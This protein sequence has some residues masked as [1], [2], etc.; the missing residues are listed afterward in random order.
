[1]RRAVWAM[2]ILCLLAGCQRQT[3]AYDP[4]TALPKGDP[5]FPALTTSW[6]ID[7]AGVLSSATISEGDDICQKLQDDGI[8][9]VAVVVIRGVK[10]PEEWATHYGRW[11]RLGRKGL[12]TEGGNNGVVWLIRPDAELR[13]TVSVG[14]G[15]P[16]FTA[17]DYAQIMDAAKDYLN[18][19][20]F[21]VGVLTI[22][23]GTDKR[24]REL[25]G[26]ANTTRGGAGR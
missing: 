2:G 22:V 19:N 14:R 8:A 6:I 9:E 11:L 17:S 25:Y 20:N 7:E 13:M 26:R 16:D 10:H 23:R 3:A 24:L 21:D 15:L 1:M 4:N 18:F 12:S 5:A